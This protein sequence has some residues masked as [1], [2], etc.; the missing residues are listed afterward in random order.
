MCGNTFGERG[1]S[2]VLTEWN[3][4]SRIKRPLVPH[5]G[6]FGRLQV[7]YRRTDEHEHIIYIHIE[8]YSTL[9]L[10]C[11][12]KQYMYVYLYTCTTIIPFILHAN[13]NFTPRPY[14]HKTNEKTLL[15]E[16]ITL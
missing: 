13:Y 4:Q 14:N 11:F 6:T 15:G 9:L 1:G 3:N 10:L 2:L 12:S 5:V 7:L 16:I 8:V